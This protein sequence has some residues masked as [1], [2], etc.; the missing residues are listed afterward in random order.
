MTTHADP[1]GSKD[2][3]F[4][5]AAD[6]AEDLALASAPFFSF[7]TWLAV[8]ALTG[9][10]NKAMGA[11]NT[12]ALTIKES[13]FFKRGSKKGEVLPAQ[14]TC[15]TRLFIA[16][17]GA[18]QHPDLYGFSDTQSLLAPENEQLDNWA[19]QEKN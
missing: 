1:T 14:C 7:L 8:S 6:L 12:A 11:I 18:P 3:F 10:E 16:P 15:T 2:Y 4:F 5:L 17:D 9:A 19:I 13:I